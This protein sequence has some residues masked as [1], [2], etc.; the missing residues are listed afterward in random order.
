M[1]SSFPSRGLYSPPM[2]KAV[3]KSAVEEK[4]RA[5]KGSPAL[6]LARKVLSIEAEAVQALV[7]RLDERF[8]G[9]LE[10]ILRRSGR[11][12]VSGMGKSGHIAR[13]IASTLSST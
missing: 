4:R 7:E 5:D 12:I 11:V 13:K 9:A 8:I 10:L 6:A 2:I 3:R 1:S